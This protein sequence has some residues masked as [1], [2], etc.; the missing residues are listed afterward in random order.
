MSLVVKSPNMTDKIVK[1]YI[2]IFQWELKMSRR[3][4]ALRSESK[5]SSHLISCATYRQLHLSV[6][7]SQSQQELNHL[8]EIGVI[9]D[10]PTEWIISLA[11]E[12]KKTSSG[13]LRICFYPRM[14]ILHLRERGRGRE[15]HTPNLPVLD[16]IL[17]IKLF[18]L[19]FLF[20]VDLRSGHWHYVL[21]T[22][23]SCT[24]AHGWNR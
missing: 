7:R 1:H 4:N 13:G 15:R 3:G 14:T 20:T 19:R 8:Q 10:E 24:T 23:T 6:F 2:E 12:G 5:H 21:T 16:N 9:I 18:E 11:E 17:P 22:F